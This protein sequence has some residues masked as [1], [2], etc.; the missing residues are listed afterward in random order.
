MEASAVFQYSERLKHGEIRVLTVRSDAFDTPV[1]CTISLELLDESPQYEAL[2]YAWGGYELCQTIWIEGRQCK[3]TQSV[4]EALQWLR[5]PGKISTLWIDAICINQEDILEKNAQ[6][7]MMGTIYE[8][9]ISTRV[10]LGPP[11]PG[12]E[13]ALDDVVR[14]VAEGV[15]QKALGKYR[16]S[17][18][19]IIGRPWHFRVWTLQEVVLSRHSVVSYGHST[20]KIEYISALG[21]ALL[22]RPFAE[23]AQVAQAWH[24]E[25]N[26]RSLVHNFVTSIIAV[27][28]IHRCIQ[29]ATVLQSSF[30][31]LPSMTVGRMCADPRD[32]I[33][34]LRGIHERTSGG[35]GIAIEIDYSMSVV[36]VYSRVTAQGLAKQGGADIL[37]RCLER[38][39]PIRADNVERRP[40]LP[41]WVPD[42]SSPLVST[43]FCARIYSAGGKLPLKLSYSALPTHFRRLTLSGCF[44]SR[45]RERYPR[46]PRASGDNEQRLPT[47]RWR[48]LEELRRWALRRRDVP[49]PYLE[50]AEWAFAQTLIADERPIDETMEVVRNHNRP[51]ST[52]W[53]TWEMPQEDWHTRSYQTSGKPAHVIPESDVTHIHQLTRIL[54]DLIFVVMYSGHFALTGSTV[55]VDDEIVVFQGMPMPFII[56][57]IPG[58]VSSQMICPAYVHGFMDGEA[59]EGVQSGEYMLQEFVIE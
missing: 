11:A 9:A 17:M 50:A 21:S 22:K 30:L 53:R 57:H 25:R 28:T 8:R 48:Q 13:S 44:I 23:T 1:R 38:C 4:F 36:E 29:T 12:L 54:S 59:M 19:E 3:V 24:M 16:D 40:K 52:P 37:V 26:L 35:N 14:L 41:S 55:C 58:G 56:R 31:L 49:S 15:T 27:H 10:W 18:C 34:A 42:W 51:I 46:L 45:V 20:C 5:E 47:C 7:Q 6:V 43:L 39:S 2:S 33:F 32:H